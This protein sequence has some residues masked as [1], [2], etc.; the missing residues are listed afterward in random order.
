[1]IR[2]SMVKKG[3]ESVASVEFSLVFLMFWS[4]F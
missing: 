2:P 3:G 4:L 1:M